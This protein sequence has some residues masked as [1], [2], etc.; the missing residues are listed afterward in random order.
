MI[1]RD[2][3]L[4]DMPAV[5]AIYAVEVLHG[6]ASFEEVPPDAP[7]LEARRQAVV[8]QGLPWLVAERDGRVVGYAYAGPYRPRPAY[9]HTVECSVYVDAA[10]RG[11]GVARAL[12]AG[13]IARCEAGGWRQMIAVIGDRENV[14]S[15]GLHV[16]MGFRHVG[17]LEAVG[18]KFGR[19]VDSVLMQRP[20]G[21]GTTG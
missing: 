14:A 7:T 21:P 12:L 11:G 18:F 13:L 19:W 16:A 10:A 17:T 4:A 15:I 1:V 20:L 2:A 6:L 8:A 5:Q 3:R 9:R